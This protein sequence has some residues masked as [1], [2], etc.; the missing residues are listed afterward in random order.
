MRRLHRR[1]VP[2]HRSLPLL[3]EPGITVVSA[4]LD[5]QVAHARPHALHPQ[6]R[7][8]RQGR[9]VPV[10]ASLQLQLAQRPAPGVK[11]EP[12]GFANQLAAQLRSRVVGGWVGRSSG[13][14]GSG[15]KEQLGGGQSL[16]PRSGCRDGHLLLGVQQGG[17][18]RMAWPAAAENALK[19]LRRQFS[20]C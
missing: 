1:A 20:R 17:C 19:H 9:P 13:T 11:R 7:W 14:S 16:W 8:R 4:E 18:A 5:S 12:P 15:G 6:R 2:R 10:N 3:H